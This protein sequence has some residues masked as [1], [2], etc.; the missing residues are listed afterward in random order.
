MAKLPKSKISDIYLKHYGTPR[1]SGRY[2]WG[3]GDDPEQRGRSFIG[4]VKE[5][6]DKGMKDTEIAE[7][8]GMKTSEMR[9]RITISRAAIKQA[10][11]G[12]ANRLKDHGYSNTEI[13]RKM[14]KNES[15]VR[16]LLDPVAYERSQKVVNTAATLKDQVAKKK[17][18]DVGI[19]VERHMGVNRTN[20]KAA[21]TM[22]ED[23]GYNQ[24]YMKTKQIATGKYT[25]ILTLT[26]PE[27]TWEQTRANKDKIKTVTD[28]SDDG[29]RTFLGLQTPV[30]V[31]SKRVKVKY[32]E[33][34]GVDKDGVIELRRGVEDISLGDKRYAQVRIAVDGTHY[35]KG[36]A[37]Y[38]DDL[39]KGI[40]LQFNTNKSNSG[41][42]L[43]ALK[44][45]KSDPDN[46]FGSSVRQKYY[47]D[48]DGNKKLSALNIVG[49]KDKGGEEGDWSG[50]SKNLAS[51]M[52]SKQS[53]QLAKQ[54]L[55]LAKALKQEE[56]DEILSIT[57]P[58]VKK[59]LLE[60]FSDGCDSDAVH[61]K[62]ASL[63]RQRSHVI[64]PLPE[65]KDNEIY[66]PNY[67][68]GEQVVLIRYP[69][70]GTFEIPE[71]KVNN[72]SKSGR[73]LLDNAVDA[74]GINPRVAERL[75]GAD[76]DGDTV[77]VIPNNGKSIKSTPALKG[78]QDFDPKIMYPAYEGMPKMTAQQKGSEMGKVSNLIADMTIKGAEPAEVARAVRHSMTV[79]DAEKHNLDYKRSADE[80]GIAQL[81]KKYQGG[82]NKGASTLISKATSQDRPLE[83]KDSYK[84]DPKTGAKI[85]EL[86]NNTYVDKNGKTVHRRMMSTKM[87][88]TDD[89]M[90]LSSGTRIEAI[91]GD[92]ANSMKSLG[93]QARLEQT[94]IKNVVYNKSAKKAYKAEVDSLD[95][96]LNEALKNA[97][98]ERQAQL[99]ANTVV[100]AKRNS[101]PDMT[102][103]E[104]K[105]VKFQAL[106]EGRKRNGAGKQQIKITNKEWEAIQAGA[107][108]NSKL[109]TILRNADSDQVRQLATPRTTTTLTATKLRRAELMLRSGATQAEVAD[110]L[111]VSTATLHKS[112]E[113]GETAAD[114]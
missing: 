54:Q 62:A 9:E 78:L 107:V 5:L 20:L 46:P 65:L 38:N 29:G 75:S 15:S 101:N 59:R 92:W 2:P 55:D 8:M 26:A 88:E 37:M 36:M 111:G 112:M 3:S 106:D 25:T 13:G 12:T 73:K 63:P 19:G 100:S 49:Y 51:Q 95:S 103:D 47:V 61:L 86:T 30:S 41:N 52:L 40:D 108:S 102:K 81:K 50:W 56:F 4:Y 28:F 35:L 110:T 10:E 48:A 64:L 17:F 82:A 104:L 23:E 93:N 11:F 32:A 16:A 89:A 68:N 24:Y 105:K 80:N 31:D 1:K 34:G 43:D 91:Y 66:A 77:L 114:N 6:K 113:L 60:D 94:K 84:I 97:P 74:V 79:I 21:L 57:N 42:K 109:V 71:L 45:M 98:L 83:R 39:P 70:G 27:T 44:A 69:H 72:K 90:T 58:A 22:L 76:F 96:K 87:A 14:G 67:R 85:Y 18:V 7:V 53:P 33:E 99:Y